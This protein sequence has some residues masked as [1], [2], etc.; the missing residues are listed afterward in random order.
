VDD[1]P[2][3]NRTALRL[4]ISQSRPGTKV[5]LSLIRNGKAEKAE[6]EL[7]KLDAEVAMSGGGPGNTGPQ[8]ILDGITLSPLTPELREQQNFPDDLTGLVV[9]EVVPGSEYAESL[10]VGAVIVEINRV[11]ITDL[12]SAK[13]ALQKGRNILL[14]NYGG[15]FRFVTITIK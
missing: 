13:K 4:M 14:V 7:G 15:A 3:E 11:G 6:V 5:T 8:S 1:R 2:V 12:A 9:I 10:P